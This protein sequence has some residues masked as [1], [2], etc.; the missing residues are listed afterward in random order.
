M[1]E[2][3]SP[4]VRHAAPPP[5]PSPGGGGSEQPGARE[6][7]SLPPP[8][9][10][11]GGGG[12]V[13]Q[14]PPTLEE[15]EQLTPTDDFRRFVTPDTPPEVKSAALKKLFTDPHFNQMDGLD[16]YIDD[17]SKPDPM[18][19]EMLRKLAASKFLKLF[20]DEEKKEDEED[21]EAREVTTDPPP[22]NV[23]QSQA[24]DEQAVPPTDDHADTDLRLQQ[25]DAAGPEGPG[26]RAS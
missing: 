25:D 22:Q 5:P 21:E 2:E 18:P 10:E 17:Y 12:A 16:V 14:P 20:D 11:G 6:G 9:G 4:D 15:A 3:A 23:A 1:P 13:Y 19:P 24:P 7:E 8:P 26:R